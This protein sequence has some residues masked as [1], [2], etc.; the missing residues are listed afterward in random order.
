[1]NGNVIT[2]ATEMVAV[3]FDASPYL[4]RKLSALTAHRSAFGL[5]ADTLNKPPPHT[6]CACGP[7]ARS[8]LADF[9]DGPENVELNQFQC[10]S[11]AT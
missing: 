7:V 4:K 3:V 8:P 10:L 1:M 5:T 9:F 6:C 2:T 11:T